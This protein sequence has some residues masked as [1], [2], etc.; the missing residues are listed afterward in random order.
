MPNSQITP[1][2]GITYSRAE[3]T[4]A[5][6][7]KTGFEPYV[8]VPSLLKIH[9]TLHCAL[10]YCDSTWLVVSEGLVRE[11]DDLDHLLAC[12]CQGKVPGQSVCGCE[13][14]AGHARRVVSGRRDSV[15]RR[16]RIE[17]YR[18]NP[19]QANTVDPQLPFDPQCPPGGTLA[20]LGPHHPTLSPIAQPGSHRTIPEPRPTIRW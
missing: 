3:I 15:S 7:G 6:T 10:A 5:L 12:T 8:S 20:H 13:G 14:C 9:P 18:S 1:S 19:A 11:R 16:L 17:S 4:N 2:E